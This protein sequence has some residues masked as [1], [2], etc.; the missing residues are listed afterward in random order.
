MTDTASDPVRAT[1]E[2][3]WPDL[4]NQ[5]TVAWH[6][7]Y[8]AACREARRRQALLFISFHEPSRAGR[9]AVRLDDLRRFAA[10]HQR[11]RY[12]FARL[13][14]DHRV[15]HEGRQIRLLGHAAFAELRGRPGIAI[16]DYESK[17]AEHY[18]YVVSVFPLR[19]RAYGAAELAVMLDLPPGT[20]TQRTMI[21]AV[22]THPDAPRSAIGLP[23]HELLRETQ[24]HSKYQ[25]DMAVQ[26]HHDWETRFHRI[27]AK[28]GDMSSREV[29]AESWP[30]ESLLEAAVECV[31]SWRQ[32]EGHWD[33]VSSSHAEYGY[34]MKL[35]ANGIWYATGIFGD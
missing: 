22:R 6:N 21:F 1:R 11:Y 33:A 13:P 34:D 7:D 30:G 9:E 12:V 16:I 26:G 24:S 8:A 27:N 29:V 3:P 19:G 4:E 15:S 23:H 20:L 32:S 18:E 17:A 14:L 2:M 10:S 5:Q 25:A 35:G 28:L 31:H